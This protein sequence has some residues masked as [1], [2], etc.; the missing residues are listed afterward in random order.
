MGPI[1]GIGFTE[2]EQTTA[3]T[4]AQCGKQIIKSDSDESRT[5]DQIYN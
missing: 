5:L 1:V 3:I 2:A 4:A